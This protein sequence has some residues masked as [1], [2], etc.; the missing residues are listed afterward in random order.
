MIQ[1]TPHMRLLL[2]VEPVDFR[3]GID[4]LVAVCRQRLAADPLAGSLF[5]FSNRARRA[6]KLLSCLSWRSCLIP[7]SPVRVSGGMPPPLIPS[8]THPP[9]R[10]PLQP[11]LPLEAAER[12]QRIPQ[13]HRAKCVQLLRQLLESVVL[14]GPANH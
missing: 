3:K 6:L 9:P 8:P 5:V 13:S 10:P 12:N 4:G 7:C 2:A 14:R 11:V 1:L